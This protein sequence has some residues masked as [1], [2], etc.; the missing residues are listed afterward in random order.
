MSRFKNPGSDGGL[1]Q[2]FSLLRLVEVVLVVGSGGMCVWSL[3]GFVLGEKAGLQV[4]F[5]SMFRGFRGVG[6][7]DK[8]CSWCMMLICEFE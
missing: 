7:V 2:S 3:F 5:F 1:G 8:S 4:A 6:G